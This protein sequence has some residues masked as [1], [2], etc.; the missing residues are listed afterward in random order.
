MEKE[1]EIDTR[2][3]ADRGCRG[4]E[5]L[6]DSGGGWMKL[7]EESVKACPYKPAYQLAFPPEGRGRRRTQ[8]GEKGKE[9]SRRKRDGGWVKK[10][11]RRKKIAT[12]MR[13]AI[14]KT[15]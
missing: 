1:R 12:K 13:G 7:E 10:K 6:R 11:R 3:F 4:L 14:M 5:D 9:R 8:V 2:E 15:E